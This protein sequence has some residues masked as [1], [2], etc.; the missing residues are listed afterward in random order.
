MDSGGMTLFVNRER[1][2][3]IDLLRWL[4]AKQTQTKMEEWNI[5]NVRSVLET[6]KLRNVVPEQAGM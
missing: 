2:Q 6:G 5:A 4:I 3:M 1:S